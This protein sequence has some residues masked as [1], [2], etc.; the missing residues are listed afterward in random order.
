MQTLQRQLN[1]AIRIIQTNL[2]RLMSLLIASKDPST[3]YVTQI[4]NLGEGPN[5]ITL[6]VVSVT[7]KTYTA[8]VNVTV[9]A[10]KTNI[11]NQGCQCRALH[12]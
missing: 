10:Q 1:L 9:T 11:V 5:T 4:Q 3:S 7:N 8:S 12:K 2:Q 6:T